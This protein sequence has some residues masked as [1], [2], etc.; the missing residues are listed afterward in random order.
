M[1][2]PKNPEFELTLPS[3]TDIRFVIE[4]LDY[5][6]K[7]RAAESVQFRQGAKYILYVPE[8]A[9]FFKKKELGPTLEFKEEAIAVQMAKALTRVTDRP[10]RVER[11]QTVHLHRQ[12]GKVYL[13]TGGI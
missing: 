10:L 9:H 13:P 3:T 7:W 8:F 2:N 6:F 1:A 4:R 5:D 11:H 12:I